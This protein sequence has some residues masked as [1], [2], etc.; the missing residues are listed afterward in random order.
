[1][2]QPLK[3]SLRIKGV[4]SYKPTGTQ[5]LDQCLSL[6][7]S[8]D[9][10]KHTENKLSRVSDSSSLYCSTKLSKVGLGKSEF[11]WPLFFRQGAKALQSF[12]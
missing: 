12:N 1:M 10:A 11:I 6:P 7:V 5:P 8:L 3:G 2:V 9:P 4:V